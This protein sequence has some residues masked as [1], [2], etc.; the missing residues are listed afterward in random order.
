MMTEVSKAPRK[1]DFFGRHNIYEAAD[2]KSAMVLLNEEDI[3]VVH[4]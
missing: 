3:D 2:I 4:L 1:S